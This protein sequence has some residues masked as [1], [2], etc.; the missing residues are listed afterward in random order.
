MHGN[1]SPMMGLSRMLAFSRTEQSP[2]EG[3]R[4]SDGPCCL[5]PVELCGK[6]PASNFVAPL[7][8]PMMVHSPE[9]DIVRHLVRLT[10]FEIAFLIASRFRLSFHSGLC[11]CVSCQITS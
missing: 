11:N 9:S 3:V 10:A 2:V 6:L 1:F 5:R 8:Q 4:A 7:L